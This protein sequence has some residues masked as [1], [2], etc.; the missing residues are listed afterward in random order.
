MFAPPDALRRHG[1]ALVFVICLLPL[2]L[3]AYSV[4]ADK[5]GP[6]PVK[7]LIHLSGEWAIRLLLLTFA[8][9]PLRRWLGWS[10]LLRYRR[11]LGLF[12]WFYVSLHLLIVA[13]FLFAWD[14]AVVLEELAERPYIIAGFAAW[15]LM[16]PMG[17][18]SNDRSLRALRA[19]W[20]RLHRLMYPLM[21]LAWLHIAWQAR[22]SY[23]D[24]FVYGLIIFCLFLGRQR[25]PA[26]SA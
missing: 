21:L 11:M 25:R 22:S 24:A 12:S 16:V 3:I 14:W 15:L 20:R 18:T 4:A 17:L 5:L 23:L 6:D 7:S 13:T 26:I 2:V 9:T 19:N 8:V 1:K 10:S